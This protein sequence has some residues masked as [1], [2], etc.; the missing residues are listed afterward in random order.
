MEEKIIDSSSMELL[1]KANMVNTDIRC[2]LENK[3][4]DEFG[5]TVFNGLS[6]DAD[7]RFCQPGTHQHQ[8]Q[9]HSINRRNFECVAKEQEVSIPY[10]N[11]HQRIHIVGQ[12][13]SSSSVTNSTQLTGRKHEVNHDHMMCENADVCQPPHELMAQN[14]FHCSTCGRQFTGRKNLL[15]HGKLHC[16]VRCSTCRRPFEDLLALRRHRV[17]HHMS[18]ANPQNSPPGPKKPTQYV[19]SHCGRMFKTST[20]LNTHVMTHTGERPLACRV[21]GCTKRFTQHSTRSFHERTH[22]DDMPH[23]CAVCGRRFKHAVGV[24]IHMSVHTGR[25][26]HRC[27]ICA[28]VFRRAC[29]LQRHSM[30]HS[31]E[32]PYSCSDCAKSFKTKRTLSRHVLALHSDEIPWRCSVCDKGFKTSGNLH[33]HLRVHTGDR[34]Y[35]CTVC[36]IRFSYSSSLKSHM[37]MHSDNN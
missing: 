23:I 30:R 10:A 35:V 31:A 15:R 7:L 28:M 6:T 33:V 29:D 21:P 4:C 19:C 1:D 14:T 26:P 8:P 17:T 20:T 11:L 9:H 22:S 24:R 12:I 32:R 25:K 2:T 27:D 3:N 18:S 36:G 13:S 34:P 37:R 5:S 16:F